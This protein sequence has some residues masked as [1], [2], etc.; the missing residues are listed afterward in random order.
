MLGELRVVEQ[1]ILRRHFAALD[2]PSDKIGPFVRLA[3][4]AAEPHQSDEFGPL[5]GRQ[6]LDFLDDLFSAEIVLLLLE[7]AERDFV[8]DGIEPSSGMSISSFAMKDRTLTTRWR[9]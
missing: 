9:R 2:R 3:V 1:I 6:P 7:G 4:A 5:A 8:I